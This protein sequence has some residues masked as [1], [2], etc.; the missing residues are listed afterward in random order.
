LPLENV[1]GLVD[2]DSENTALKTLIVSARFKAKPMPTQVK[3]FG[4][5]P[6]NLGDYDV[7]KKACERLFCNLGK[8]QFENTIVSYRI[9]FSY[10]QKNTESKV[11]KVSNKKKTS[12]YKNNGKVQNSFGQIIY[13]YMGFVIIT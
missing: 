3:L 5:D 7:I 8:V 1:R 12:N 11:N 6:D 10:K 9:V 4:I 13:P 2:R